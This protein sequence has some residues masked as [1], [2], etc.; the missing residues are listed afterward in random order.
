MPK[1]VVVG[2]AGGVPDG[3]RD[4]GDH[5]RA[6]SHVSA[7]PSIR[8][9]TPPLQVIKGNYPSALGPVPRPPPHSA[10][11]TEPGDQCR[12]GREECQPARVARSRRAVAMRDDSAPEPCTVWCSVSC[13]INKG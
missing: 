7:E 6:D 8:I 5:K 1:M 11:M 9:A 13:K 10:G 3:G 2:G 12:I 4:T